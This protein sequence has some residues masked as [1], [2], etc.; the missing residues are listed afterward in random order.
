MVSSRLKKRFEGLVA[1]AVKP[2]VD[3][4]VT[5]NAITT[6]G[7]V[8]S[9]AAGL[10]YAFWKVSPLMLPAAG[11]LLLVSGLFDSIDGV[12]ARTTGKV[13]VFGGFFD[14]VSDRYS[15]AAVIS[16]V[17]I[18][19]LCDPLWGLLALSGSLLVS[20]ARARAES[21][22]VMMTAV[23]LAERAERM[24]L[25][26]LI[27]FAAAYWIDALRYGIIILAVLA[28]LTVVQ[29]VLYFKE[30]SAQ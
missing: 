26:A 25:L 7:L 19:G 24:L 20:Y 4:G 30:K 5:P 13:T 27:T 21:A 10:C 18:G 12:I 14:S 8:V 17:I 16:G 3:A 11:V 2:L 29:R 9:L 28:H 23:G 22:G 15:D 1:G 6:L